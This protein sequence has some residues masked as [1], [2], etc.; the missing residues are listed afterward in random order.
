MAFVKPFE[1]PQ[2]S[3][4]IKIYVNFFLYN[5]LKCTGR[6][7]LT[8]FL[9]LAQLSKTDIHNKK[10]KHKYSENYIYI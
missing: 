4:K 8:N 1:A 9:G 6:E 5:L 3:V 10:I 7:R 2:R